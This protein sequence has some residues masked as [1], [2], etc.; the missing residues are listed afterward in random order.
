VVPEWLLALAIRAGKVEG[1]R[2]SAE[3]GED[4]HVHVHHGSIDSSVLHRVEHDWFAGGS[5][6]NPHVRHQT[7]LSVGISAWRN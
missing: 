7:G 3:V 6:R 4:V 1:S 5:V 2:L